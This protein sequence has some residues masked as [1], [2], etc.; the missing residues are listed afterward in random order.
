MASYYMERN[1]PVV[2]EANRSESSSSEERHTRKCNLMIPA[3]HLCIGGEESV[4]LH[5]AE[6]MQRSRFKVTVCCL[7]QRGRMGE[8]LARKGIEV[9]S[10]AELRVVPVDYLTFI[11]RLKVLRSKNIDAVPTRTTQGLVDANLC[12]LKAY[13][14]IYSDL[15]R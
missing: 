15:I 9:I 12:S 3:L 2:D 1:V 7:K 14:A 5:L 13:E 10:F 6:P 11:K 8:E 4:M